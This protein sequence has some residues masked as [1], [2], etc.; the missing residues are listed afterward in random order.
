MHAAA[1]I[2]DANSLQDASSALSAYLTSAGTDVQSTPEMYIYILYL[3]FQFMSYEMHRPDCCNP[4]LSHGFMLN[5]WCC[6]YVITGFVN[7]YAYIHFYYLGIIMRAIV[8]IMF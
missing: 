7:N 2:P 1:C 5:S 4:D 8:I 6:N 3:Y